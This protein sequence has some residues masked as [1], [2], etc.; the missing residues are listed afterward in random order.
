MVQG[1]S[2]QPEKD[3]NKKTKLLVLAIFHSNHLIA[4]APDQK[5]PKEK[6]TEVL[7]PRVDL[8][9]TVGY[10][11]EPRVHYLLPMYQS[12]IIDRH[13]DAQ[14]RQLCTCGSDTGLFS[15]YGG[16]LSC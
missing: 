5:R 10:E 9:I 3:G 1:A 6:E 16:S 11:L 13:Y 7:I 14:V 8:K 12:W 2:T 15:F 4:R